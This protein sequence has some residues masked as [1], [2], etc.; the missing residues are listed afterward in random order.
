MFSWPFLSCSPD[1]ERVGVEIPLC[2]KPLYYLLH[3][4]WLQS[5][6]IHCVHIDLQFQ[7]ND[8]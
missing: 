5:M 2:C 1:N 6:L 7:F 3:C 4:N 8:S